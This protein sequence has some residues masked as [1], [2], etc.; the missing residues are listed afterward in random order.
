MEDPV[1][2]T[3]LQIEISPGICNP[4]NPLV[5]MLRY[6]WLCAGKNVYQVIIIDHPVG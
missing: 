5:Y 3:A 1:I 4:V 2:T 6:N